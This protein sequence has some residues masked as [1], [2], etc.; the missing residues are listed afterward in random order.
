MVRP[1]LPDDEKRK[2]IGARF[3]PGDRRLIEERAK[4]NKRTPPAEIEALATAFLSSNEETTSL[5]RLIADGIATIEK[6]TGKRWNRDLRTWSAVREFLLR[7]PIEDA[8]PDKWQDDPPLSDAYKI[9]SELREDR[10]NIVQQLGAMGLVVSE[11]LTPVAPTG[12][13]LVSPLAFMDGGRTLVRLA[14]EV[15]DP[16]VERDRALNLLDKLLV[17]DNQ[18]DRNG[19]LIDSL[20]E[21]FL[22]A[23]FSGR[24]LCREFLNDIA[25]EKR[26][27]GEEH[28]PK[29]YWGIWQ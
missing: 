4:N 9:F 29:H 19:T 11:E 18:I 12:S 17:V 2:Q 5:L 20:A 15:A 21:P 26:G 10:R 1:P 24:N 25:K 13:S 3:N 23:E 6:K 8:C 28:N 14:L 22:A 27:N 7:G 16:S